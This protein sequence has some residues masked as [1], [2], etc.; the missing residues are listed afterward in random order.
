MKTGRKPADLF[1]TLSGIWW[2]LVTGAPWNQLPGKF[3]KW[4]SVYRFHLRWARRGVFSELLDLTAARSE[5]SEADEIKVIDASHLKAHQDACRHSQPPEQR[6]LGKTKGGRNCKL[7]ACVNGNGKALKL[8]LAPGNRH[9]VLFAVDVLGNVAG[10]VV[11]GDRGYDS[12]ALREH[13]SEQGGIAMIPGK[14]NR[15][16]AVFYIPEIGRRRRV[17]ENFFCRIKRH[18]RVATRYDKLSETFISF[19]TLAAIADW[20]RF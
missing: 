5:P 20:V 13:V 7:N 4:N 9:D 8:T 18:R 11:L 17:V 15:K 1:K 19:I 3:G 12:D 14:S 16:K 2:I 6:A 10:K